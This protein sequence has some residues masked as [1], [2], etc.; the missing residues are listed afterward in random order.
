MI[1]LSLENIQDFVIV[2]TVLHTGLQHFTLHKYLRNLKSLII[3]QKSLHFSG[4][5]SIIL[6]CDVNLN[7]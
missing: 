2:D 5:L 6:L 1:I 3:N 4:A 7:S